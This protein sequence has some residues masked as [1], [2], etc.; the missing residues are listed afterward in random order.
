MNS[1]NQDFRDIEKAFYSDGYQLG[2][3]TVESNLSQDSLFLSISEM[4]SAIEKLINSFTSL[5]HQ[6]NKPIHC[7]RGC[8]YCCH[9]P[10]FALDYEMQFLNSFIKKKFTKKKQEEIQNRANKN[11]SKLSGLNKSQILDSKQ[12]CPLLENGTCS[13]YEARPMACR[14][15]LSTNV[16]T[17]LEFYNNPKNKSNFPAL[18]ELPMRTG[19][20]MNEGFKS[21]LKTKG[22]IAKEFQINEKIL[23]EVG[24]SLI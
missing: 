1:T 10:V 13:T 11:Q 2:M 16:N 6:Q 22:V 23:T 9:Q 4:F 7:K 18:L 14:I 21:A 8:Y 19:R 24:L 3:R 5:A 12:P 17:C 15:Y 20:I